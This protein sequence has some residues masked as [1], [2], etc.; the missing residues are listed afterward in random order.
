MNIK[1]SYLYRDG[2][3]Y[4]QHNEIIFSN[5][6]ETDLGEI[7]K[8]ILE[9]LI[10]AQWFV[11]KDWEVADMHFA[12]YTWDDKTDHNWHEFTVIEETT[13]KTTEINSIDEF[14]SV[15]NKTKPIWI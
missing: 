8:T 4:K 10:D 9:N 3:N 6:N 13:E 12:P 5:P 14:L 2:A 11:A 1:F 7:Q 15:I